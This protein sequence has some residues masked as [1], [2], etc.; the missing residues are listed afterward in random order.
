MRLAKDNLLGVHVKD[1]APRVIRG[2]PFGEGIVPFKEVFKA[3]A[4]IGFWGMMAVEMWSSMHPDVDPVEHA[5]AARRFVDKL[6]TEA[7]K[8]QVSG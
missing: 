5:A 7:Y 8:T 6:V 4:D 2:I 1:A 3:L